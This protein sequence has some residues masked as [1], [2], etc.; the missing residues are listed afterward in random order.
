MDFDPVFLAKYPFL[1]ATKE[2]VASLGI[3][4]SEMLSHPVYGA[5]LELGR[6]RVL[7][8]MEG[9]FRPEYGDP[10]RA[11]LTVLSYP[12]ARMLAHGLG[13]A[14]VGRYA[15]GEAEAAYE[16]FRDDAEASRLIAKDLGVSETGGGMPFPQYVSLATALT[17]QS[18][19][20]KLANRLVDAGYV[21]VE[22]GEARILLREAVR[23]RVLESVDL[24]RLPEEVKKMAAG[25]RT[26]LTGDKATLDIEALDYE[27]LPPCMKAMTA[28][29][30]A[31]VSSH[32]AMF[33][34]ATFL[35]NLGL[36]TDDIV[37]VYS[38]SPKFDEEKTRY[39]LEFLTGG[40]GGTEY[41]C[42]ACATIKSQGLCKNEC[43]VKHP[44][45]HYRRHS[46][47]RPKAAA[48]V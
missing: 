28:A 41:T 9:R 46:R 2:Y 13:R 48:K 8:C 12:L 7:D 11:Q 26:A 31:G 16:L 30:E 6:L 5:S 44:L 23:N 35:A 10:V 17:R 18:P 27:A 15:Q 4:L 36:K 32:S 37:K 1:K 14:A 19:K 25:L 38:K 20:W 47:K 33:N 39:Q 24:K 40:R 42:P 22:A 45:Q 3:P 34:L 21:D 29:L 43:E